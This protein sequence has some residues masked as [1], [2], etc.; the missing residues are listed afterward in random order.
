MLHDLPD[1][2]YARKQTKIRNQKTAL[3]R[4]NARIEKLEAAL[5]PL[6]GLFLYPNDLG[7]ELALDI[8]EDPD[9]DEDANDMQSENCFVLRR[10]IKAARAALGEKKND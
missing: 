3:R 7:F 5:R 2:L 8:R 6:A 4:A 1:A 10:D 9:W